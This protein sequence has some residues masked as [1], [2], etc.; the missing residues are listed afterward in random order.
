MAA[1]ENSCH[2]CLD[3]VIEGMSRY[4]QMRREI[5]WCARSVQFCMDGCQC[6]SSGNSDIDNL[7]IHC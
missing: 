1:E 6:C 2:L 3:R 5:D 4:D 7:P